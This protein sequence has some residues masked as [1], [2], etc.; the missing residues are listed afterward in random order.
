MSN[1]PNIIFMLTDDQRYNTLGCMGNKIIHTPNIDALAY[2]G[3]CFDNAFHVA[4]I[5]MPSRASIQLGKYINQHRCGFD[6]PTD[7]TITTKEYQTSYP[8]L[9]RNSGYYTGFIGKF[10]FAITEV[11][12][13]NKDRVEQWIKGLD[14]PIYRGVNGYSSKETSMPKTEFDVWNGF[15]DQGKYRPLANGTFNGY[16]NTNND[17][18]LNEFMATEAADFLQ[19]AASQDKPF[20]LSIS[21]KA[22]HRP[23]DPAKKWH[24]Y[25]SN[26]KIPRYDND[27]PEY[28]EKLPEVVKTHS[29]NA[30][31]YWGRYS[32]PTTEDKPWKYD[33]FFEE[34]I[35]DYFA[36]ISG[37]DEAVGNVCAE[38]HRLGLHKNTII[39]YSSDNGYFFGSK[40]LGGKELLYEE[41][42]RAPLIVFDPRQPIEKRSKRIDG[43]ASIIDIYSTILDYADVKAPQ[44]HFGKSL[45]PLINGEKEEVHDAVYG[46]NDFNNNYASLEETPDPSHY[47]S[48]R[49]KYVRTT[50]YKYI[51]YQ[52]CHPVV[53]ELWDIKNDPLEE[54]NLIYNPKFK[55]VADKMRKMLDNFVEETKE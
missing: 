24:D 18:H 53:E 28:F 6:R 7:Y 47:Q 29:R 33:Q 23:F 26:I 48:I 50:D 34:D 8:V 39:I 10:G 40:Q 5:C 55:D 11:K 45:L 4:P 22:P 17:E 44:K 51:R 15:V 31:E 21:F 20:A 9:L 36:L 35:R 1:K 49:S 12:V 16:E 46:E 42:I 3:C 41:S 25:Y 37:V 32:A 13:H 54:N 43:M 30:E 38:L 2:N 14:E 27:K 52:E 19:K